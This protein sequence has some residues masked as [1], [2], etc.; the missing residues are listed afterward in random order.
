MPSGAEAGVGTGLKKPWFGLAA[1]T[2]GKK[3][4]TGSTKA[5]LMMGAS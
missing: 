2:F 5:A 3:Y 4:V 1:V